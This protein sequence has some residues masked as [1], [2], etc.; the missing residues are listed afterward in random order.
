M[1][2]RGIEF[3]CVF[4]ASGARGFFGD[5]YWFHRYWRPLGLNFSGSTF[6]AKT[7]TLEARAG[8]MP[9]DGDTLQPKR[10]APDCIV[11]KPWKNAVLNAVGL[12]GPGFEKLLEQYEWQTRT[13]PFLLSFM[14]V[15]PKYMERLRDM[16]DF[17]AILKRALPRFRAP[18][19]LQLNFSCPNAGIGHDDLSSEVRE[20]LSVARSLGIPLLVKINALVSAQE[21]VTIAN[22][23][24]CDAI[25]CSNTIPWGQMPDRIDWHRLFGSDVSPLA[26]YGGGG[27]SGAPLLPVVTAWIARA[28]LAGIAKPIVGSGGILCA[29]DARRMFASGASAI[30]IGSVALLRPWRVRSIIRAAHD[31]PAPHKEERHGNVHRDPTC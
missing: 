31:A 15:Q 8:N 18:I 4:N 7:S 13:E 26:R 16:F 28:R 24:A 19:G 20:T 21:A 11:I 27:L 2:L 12:S 14:S 5:G 23:P 17:S 6:V 29:E 9:F 30:E 1:K 25:V 22:H 3:G 10:L